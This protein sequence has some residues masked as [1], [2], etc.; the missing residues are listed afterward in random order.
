M[1][2]FFKKLRCS[3]ESELSRNS[4]INRKSK[5]KG[6]NIT[7]YCSITDE[8]NGVESKLHI[9]HYF[10]IDIDVDAFAH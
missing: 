8:E 10:N 5:Q 6:L 7:E 1:K 2:R 3:E 4:E 9:R